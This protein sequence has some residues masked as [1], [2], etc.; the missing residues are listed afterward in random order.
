MVLALAM[1]RVFC[2]KHYCLPGGFVCQ[3]LPRDCEA[4]ELMTCSEDLQ[5]VEFC[6]V[7]FAQLVLQEAYQLA[8]DQYAQPP[9]AIKSLLQAWKEMCS[10]LSEGLI[11]C[12][13]RQLIEQALMPRKVKRCGFA[14]SVLITLVVWPVQVLPFKELCDRV[15]TLFAPARNAWL[16]DKQKEHRGHALMTQSRIYR[17]YAEKLPG[18]VVSGSGCSKPACA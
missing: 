11:P 3:A 2:A 4:W 13:F 5:R 15:D 7:F 14:F 8:F 16:D 1:L 18:T 9:E 12:A 6:H 17:H 10:F